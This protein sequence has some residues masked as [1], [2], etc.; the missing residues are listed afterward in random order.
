[1]GL[2]AQPGGGAFGA[3]GA[4]EGIAH[5]LSFALFGGDTKHPFGRAEH[6]D[7]QCER[8]LW[9]GGEVWKMAFVHLLLAAGFVQLDWFH[10]MRFLEIRDWRIVEGEM[11]VFAD[12]KTTEINGL[13]L[14]QLGVALAFVEGQKR[15]AGNVME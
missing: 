13:G 12:P 3:N 10:A 8:I 9:D 11:A 6:R 5:G 1:M 2:F 15:I 14:Q 7:R 4:A